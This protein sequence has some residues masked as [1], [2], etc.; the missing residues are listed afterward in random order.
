[1]LGKFALTKIKNAQSQQEMINTIEN[2]VE[3][4]VV[5]VEEGSKG[6]IYILQLTTQLMFPVFFSFLFFFFFF[7]LEMTK[8]ITYRQSTRK[9]MW[10]IVALVIV[11]LIVVGIVVY[12]QVRRKMISVYKKNIH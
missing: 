9:K 8:A 7:F 12:F 2:Q 10:W 1:M 3:N 6:T 4:T 11:I 5:Y